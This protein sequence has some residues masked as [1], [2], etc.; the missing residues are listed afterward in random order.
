MSQPNNPSVQIALATIYQRS[1]RPQRALATLERMSDLQNPQFDSA[2]TWALKGAALASLGQVDQSRLCMKEAAQRANNKDHKVFLQLAQLQ[3]EMGDLADARVN[4]GR[5][6][7]QEP[8]NPQALTIQQQLE[9][10]FRDLPVS[11]Q[12][13]ATIHNADFITTSGSNRP[14]INSLPN[15]PI[16]NPVSPPPSK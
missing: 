13:I 10:K 11:N 1:G 16:A 6:L 15:A 8:N 5:V 7:S 12:S 9:Q 3:A 2:S 14:Q 4:L